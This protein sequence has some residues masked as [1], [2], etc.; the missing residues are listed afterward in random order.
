MTAQNNFIFASNRS[1][2]IFNIIMQNCSETLAEDLFEIKEVCLTRCN[3]F[4]QHY[5]TKPGSSIGQLKWRQYK[6]CVFYLRLQFPLE[7]MIWS[8]K[9]IRL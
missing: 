3:Y 2:Y 4:L 9:P 1:V 8:G 7:S 6:S 5:F